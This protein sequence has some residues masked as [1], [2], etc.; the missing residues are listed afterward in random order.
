MINTLSSHMGYQIHVWVP[1]PDLLHIPSMFEM[2]TSMRTLMLCLNLFLC[3]SSMTSPCFYLSRRNK[4]LETIEGRLQPPMILSW[5]KISGVSTSC[6]CVLHLTYL[7]R[8]Y[9]QTLI[10]FL[11][12]VLLFN[13]L[14]CWIFFRPPPLNGRTWCFSCSKPK[15]KFVLKNKIVEYE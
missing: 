13:M 8:L 4:M 9:F 12:W 3:I 6:H 15:S 1:Y 10:H 14:Q 2:I 7:W 5:K 11:S